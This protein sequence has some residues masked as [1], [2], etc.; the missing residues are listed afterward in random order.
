[1]SSLRRKYNT[2]SS[3]CRFTASGLPQNL[4]NAPTYHKY[5]KYPEPMQ[6]FHDEDL[7]CPD[8]PMYAPSS[9]V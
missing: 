7:V 8:S 3:H 5:P 4:R 1:M 6:Y 9:V 2:S